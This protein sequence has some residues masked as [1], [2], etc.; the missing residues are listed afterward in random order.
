MRAY[1]CLK[2]AGIHTVGQLLELDDEALLSIRQLGPKTLAEIKDKLA[3]HRL[4]SA[5][6]REKTASGNTHTSAAK[7]ET[8]SSSS[9]KAPVSAY[10]LSVLRLSLR[11]YNALRRAG[12]ET[13][14][15]LLALSTEQIAEIRNVGSKLLA[16]IQEKLDAYLR[17]HPLRRQIEVPLPER[18]ADVPPGLWNKLVSQGV[19]SLEQL[20]S[21]SAEEL[22]LDL[23]L[24]VLQVSYLQEL[25]AERGLA[26]AEKPSKVPLVSSG[27]S[28]LVQQHRDTLQR[29]PIRRLA[30]PTD[31]QV[32]LKLL[33]IN[34]VGQLADQSRI[35]LE[36]MH[37][38][39]ASTTI[40]TIQEHLDTYIAWV[41]EHESWEDEILGRG[42]SP[43]H[44]AT[45]AKTTLE[46]LVDEWCRALDERQRLVIRQ[47]CGIEDGEP[48][49]F[50]E[51]GTRLGLSRERVRQI[52]GQILHTL[53]DP[54][55]YAVIRPLVVLLVYL[56]EQAGGLMDEPQI[57]AALRRELVIGNVDPVGV[58]QLI[59]DLD[60]N[61]KWLSNARAW[62]LTRYPLTEV[63]G[64]QK[65]FAQLLTQHQRPLFV[66]ELLARFKE[67][68]FYQDRHSELD[69][70][71]LVTCLQLHPSIEVDDEKMCTSPRWSRSRL[72]EIIQALRELGEPAHYSKIAKTINVG[73]PP[74]QHITD[75]T[76]RNRLVQHPELFVWVRL[77]GTYGLTEWDLEQALSYEDTL[78]QILQQASHPLTFQQILAEIPAFR[79]YYEESSLLLTLGTN[80]R[81]RSFPGDTYG[82]A[83]WQE[84]EVV[85]EDYRLRRLFEGVEVASSHKPKPK[86]METLNGVDS[87]I[88]RVRDDAH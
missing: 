74:E 58:A 54:Q 66:E 65:R 17:D 18:P 10:P 86:L 76:V 6:E 78:V 3:R 8:T 81:F 39:H 22:L 67:T 5:T 4:S 84:D 1:N 42:L 36:R 50:E 51:V 24:D 88:A 19:E 41:T 60:D 13:L 37:F 28:R 49:T 47:R 46:G 59:F 53:S 73:L 40:E 35:V 64:I 26:L 48:A 71:F 15:D 63:D 43:V 14:G 57:E 82:L 2:R 38:F 31:C 25:L 79:P 87:F 52:Q 44:L 55:R 72:H 56:L 29:I 23:N 45:L 75:R 70:S 21:Y 11:S 20:A 12:I 34:S 16:E 9:S 68:R 85:N 27:L 61:F 33:G 83:E 7:L 32:T 80:E 69:D 30:L 62:G 77:R